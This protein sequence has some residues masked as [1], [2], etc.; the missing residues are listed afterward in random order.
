MEET[1]PSRPAPTSNRPIVNLKATNTTLAALVECE[2]AARPSVIQNPVNTTDA[3]TNIR[4]IKKN[5]YC[6]TMTS[7][8]RLLSAEAMLSI[9]MANPTILATLPR[10]FTTVR[11]FCFTS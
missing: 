5:T 9:S 10:R 4:L 7:G 11:A 8:G 2:E 1:R 3:D 6:H